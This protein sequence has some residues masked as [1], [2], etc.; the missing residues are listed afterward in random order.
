MSLLL[1]I[2]LSLT[3]LMAKKWSRAAF[4][5]LPTQRYTK[6]KCS[7][8]SGRIF[9]CETVKTFFVLSFAFFSFVIVT[10]VC[11]KE[12]W[13]FQPAPKCQGSLDSSY[14]H[15]FWY[16]SLFSQIK[17]LDCSFIW[18][19]RKL[20]LSQRSVATGMWQSVSLEAKSTVTYLLLT[21]L[22]LEVKD[23]HSLLC[24]G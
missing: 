21:G 14:I 6:Y 17:L 15:P 18:P 1:A 2:H 22:P 10:E 20:T 3:L 19:Q 11:A 24:K 8:F 13:R 12:I 23:L 5:L 4:H 16:S 9:C 7:S